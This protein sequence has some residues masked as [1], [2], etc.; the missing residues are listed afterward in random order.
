MAQEDLEW[1]PLGKRKG[2]PTTKCKTHVQRISR[3][4]GLNK[5]VLNVKQFACESKRLTH[6][7]EGRKEKRKTNKLIC[8]K[9]N[10]FLYYIGI[11]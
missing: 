11:I 7:G 3:E 5:E 8:A 4:R 2:R 6:N 10:I 9:Y 1:T